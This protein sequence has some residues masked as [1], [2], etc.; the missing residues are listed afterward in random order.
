MASGQTVFQVFPQGFQIAPSVT[1]ALPDTNFG[2]VINYAQNTAAMYPIRFEEHY[3]GGGITLKLEYNAQTATSGNVVVR[4][5]FSRLNSG[6]QSSP[7]VFA[8]L[9][10]SVATA[11]PGTVGLIVVATITFTN[12]QINGMVGGDLG[13]IK[14][15]RD[16]AG[17]DTMAGNLQFR[18]AEGRE[19]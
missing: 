17:T 9:V 1:S 15:D 4:A 6:T 5:G 18:G 19:T 12:S 10:S 13:W 11:V 7:P 8:S 16:V 2:F 14:I 3:G